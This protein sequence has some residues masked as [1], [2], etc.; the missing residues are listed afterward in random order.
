MTDSSGADDRRPPRQSRPQLLPL[1][2]LAVIALS[3]FTGCGSSS[4]SSSTASSAQPVANTSTSQTSSSPGSQTT[5]ATA[6]GAS[7]SSPELILCQHEGSSTQV[8]ALSGGAEG[9]SITSLASFSADEAGCSVSPDLTKLAELSTTSE[10]SKVAGYVP[11]SGGSFVDA[12]GHETNGYSG[13]SIT[14]EGPLFDPVTGDLWWNSEGHVWSS[15]LNGTQPQEHGTGR[16]QGFSPSGEPSADPWT[17]SPDGSLEAYVNHEEPGGYTFQVGLAIG[18]TSAIT[19]AC[20]N[21]G[22][23]GNESAA[24]SNLVSDCRGVASTSFEGDGC[25]IAETTCESFVGLISDS[26]FIL[27]STPTSQQQRFYRITFRLAGGKIDIVSRVA[28][29]P[30]TTKAIEWAGVSPDGKTLWY[31]TKA[32]GSEPEATEQGAPELYIVPTDTTTEHPTSVSVTPATSLANMS[33]VGW[34]WHEHWYGGAP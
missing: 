5:P 31:L 20:E 22:S 15:S 25:H 24:A 28:I 14:D 6:A 4:P 23:P 8:M 7:N 19:S 16:V 30:P 32:G 33:L 21:R 2:A 17:V 26:Q 27:E 10:G 11:A 13:A 34:R 1:V 29:T 3:T 12:A 18:P 9:V